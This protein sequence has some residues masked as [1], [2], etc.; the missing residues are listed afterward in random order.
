VFLDKYNRWVEIPSLEPVNFS[1][2]DFDESK[3]EHRDTL[4]FVNHPKLSR[5]LFVLSMKDDHLNGFPIMPVCHTNGELKGASK[6]KIIPILSYYK[7]KNI[8]RTKVK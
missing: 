3:G 2:F 4:A 6:K 5:R 7:S 1:G 8:G